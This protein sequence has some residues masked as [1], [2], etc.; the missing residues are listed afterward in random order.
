MENSQHINWNY[1]VLKCVEELNELAT[2]LIQQ[3][4]KP[5]KDLSGKII[6]ELGDAKYRMDNLIVKYYGT[7]N[8]KDRIERKWGRP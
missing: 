3:N 2:V 1:D 7:E 6:E 4:N 5:H 8:V